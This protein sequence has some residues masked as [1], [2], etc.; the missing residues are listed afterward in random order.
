MLPGL[1][2]SNIHDSNIFSGFWQNTI[3]D[4]QFAI[5]LHLP[6]I[7]NPQ[8]IA[9]LININLATSA[10]IINIFPLPQEF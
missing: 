10:L 4:L 7:I 8:N 1:N 5:G 6:D 3:R 2:L 9:I